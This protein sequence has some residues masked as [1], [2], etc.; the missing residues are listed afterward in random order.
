MIIRNCKFNLNI[1]KLNFES[2]ASTIFALST[3][4]KNSGSPIAVI[5][6]S[7]TETL[8]V[9]DLIT[10][11]KGHIY[12]D[13]PRKCFVHNY[14]DPKTN[15]LIDKGMILWFPQPK[16]YTGEDVCEFHMHG[17]PAVISKMLS[18]LGEL[19]GCRP[20]K[21]GEF[22]K[23]ALLNGKVQMIEAE[24]INDLISA[25]TENQRRR[26]L[27]GISGLLD[28]K[29]NE[30]RQTIIKLMAH[31]EAFIDFHEEELIDPNLIE[32]IKK[33]IALIIEKIN[34]HVK[35]TKFKS[36]LIK[37]G[38]YIAIIGQANVGKSSLIN[39]LCNYCSIFQLLF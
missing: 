12:Q 28:S 2:T 9:I 23:R 37:D 11:G 39:K 6:V 17:S 22:T 35:N 31:I 4:I 34:F 33:D 29:F 36:D 7:G 18:V 19:T 1:S 24:G 38:F 15:E 3:N 14:Y 5:R 20:A 26:A 16:S 25:K 10:N 8:N 21:P 32:N 30:W 27:G 13:N